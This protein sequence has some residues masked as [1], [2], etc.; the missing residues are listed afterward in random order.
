MAF[1][2]WVNS[3]INGHW[4]FNVQLQRK[5]TRRL[6]SLILLTRCK[7][8]QTNDI[9]KLAAL[10]THCEIASRIALA[11]A[12]Q[13]TVPECAVYIMK[14][15][16]WYQEIPKHKIK[17]WEDKK[18][19][20]AAIKLL[21]DI[22]GRKKYEVLQLFAKQNWQSWIQ[23]CTGDGAIDLPV[24]KGNPGTLPENN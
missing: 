19:C 2:T 20:K 3:V 16:F 6:R 11:A 21:E 5:K 17:N 13:D 4:Q 23:N 15:T 18:S 9:W 14:P 12:M 1:L 10:C 8:S 22:K 24:G 7:L